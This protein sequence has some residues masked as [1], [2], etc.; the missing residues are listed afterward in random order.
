MIKRVSSLMCL[1]S[2]VIVSFALKLICLQKVRRTFYNFVISLS[3]KLIDY[4]RIVC[5]KLEIYF[6]GIMISAS[7]LTSYIHSSCTGLLWF[8][9][10]IFIGYCCFFLPHDDLDVVRVKWGSS[11]WKIFLNVFWVSIFLI[12][13][14]WHEVRLVSPDLPYDFV[15][16]VSL[17]EIKSHLLIF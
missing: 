5:L 9:L 6:M 13:S 11:F 3:T 12:C 17:D 7:W 1:V 15:G 8:R 10:H 14:S 16:G 4:C 2:I